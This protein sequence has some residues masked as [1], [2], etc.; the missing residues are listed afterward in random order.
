MK[1]RVI[2]EGAPTPRTEQR[3][4]R[5]AVSGIARAAPIVGLLLSDRQTTRE[6]GRTIGME[7]RRDSLA[8]SAAILVHA[9]GLLCAGVIARAVSPLVDEASLPALDEVT[10]AG[11]RETGSIEVDLLSDERVSPPERASA[12]P[13]GFAAG[14]EVPA[15]R[16]NTMQARRRERAPTQAPPEA[17]VE[18]APAEVAPA[19]DPGWL[20]NDDPKPGG[21]PS[22]NGAPIW[23]IPGVLTAPS[24]AGTKPLVP[25]A[26]RAESAAS[27]SGSPEQPTALFPT[28]GTLA[29]AVVEEVSSSTTPPVSE[30]RFKLTI[31]AEGRLVSAELL[32]ANEG[33]RAAWER[34]ARAVSKRFAGRSMPLPSSFAGGGALYVTVSSRVVMPDGTEHGIP[35]PRSLLE[36]APDNEYGRIESP[37]NDRFRSPMSS[38]A[39]APKTVTVG[40]PFVMDLSNI[41][42][43]RR[44]VVRAQVQAVPLATPSR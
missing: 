17:T 5:F 30:S 25:R 27:P 26:S 23:T 40:V 12:A 20:P 33:D 42:A 6:A 7:R 18:Q 24:A 31:D 4:D 14:V 19:P 36:K 10:E 35:R 11:T 2:P 16:L 15:S 28:A 8:L 21:A 37:L 3:W 38:T 29:S 44:R 1:K 32:S 22:L 9:A 41:G 34:V 13:A 39:P 43:T